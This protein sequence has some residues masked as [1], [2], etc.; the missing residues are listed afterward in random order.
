MREV[1]DKRKRLQARA[2]EKMGKF[3]GSHMIPVVIGPNKHQYIIDHHHLALALYYEGLNHVLVSVMADLRALELDSFWI[4]LDHH[5]WVHP[6]D[7][8]GHRRGFGDIPDSVVG[9]LDDPFRSLAGALRRAGGFAKESTPFNE[10]LWA[11]F[12][13]RRITKQSLD[14]NFKSALTQ[15]LHLAE[16]DDAQY[17]PGWCGAQ[18]EDNLS[19]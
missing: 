5:G 16:S 15:A 12:L 7:T 14:E 13:R 11:D 3:L 2:P 19:F 17:L 18:S 1:E 8:G 4:V 6:Y 9:L 10:F